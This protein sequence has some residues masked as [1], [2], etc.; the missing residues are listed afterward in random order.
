MSNVLVF[1]EQQAGAP[2]KQGLASVTFGQHA[3]R[4]TGGE[5]HLLVVGNDAAKAGDALKGFGA[6]KV[7]VVEDAALNNYLA[8]SYTAVLEQA[9]KAVGATLIA[10]GATSTSKD[11]L[12]RVAVRFDAAMA[13]DVMSVESAHIA[14]VNVL[15]D[16][17]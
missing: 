16:S 8:E 9:A 5:L 14:R 12:P 2:K 7:H 4:A 3:A 13:S 17:T 11:F 1:V 15:A 6:A 10:A